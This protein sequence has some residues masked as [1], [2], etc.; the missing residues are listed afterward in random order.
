MDNLEGQLVLNTV[1]G[2]ESEVAL[3]VSGLSSPDRLAHISAGSQ[4]GSQKAA[5]SG[6]FFVVEQLIPYKNCG[7]AVGCDP[8]SWSVKPT[9]LLPQTLVS[10][11]MGACLVSPRWSLCCC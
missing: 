9:S 10:M 4:A 1:W 8:L 3:C 6:R 5:V 11:L 7:L 2:C